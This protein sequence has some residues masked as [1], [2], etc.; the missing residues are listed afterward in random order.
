[1]RELKK[2]NPG[3]VVEPQNDR[4]PIVLVRRAS[5]R[6]H[7]R[8]GASSSSNDGGLGHG[9]DGVLMLLLLLL[10]D[11]AGKGSDFRV[12][13]GEGL[14]GGGTAWAAH[15]FAGDIADDVHTGGEAVRIK[16][17]ERKKSSSALGSSY[18]VS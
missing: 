7:H 13:G 18:R 5:R 10:E 16:K 15:G 9:D 12:K 2:T 8:S 11:G 6:N 17:R 3:G 4:Q 1:L 14:D